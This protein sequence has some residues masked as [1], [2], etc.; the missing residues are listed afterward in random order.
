MK[1]FLPSFPKTKNYSVPFFFS[2][3]LLFLSLSLPSRKKILKNKFI[4]EKKNRIV[5]IRKFVQ[6]SKNSIFY[7]FV[8]NSMLLKFQCGDLFYKNHS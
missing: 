5:Q 2:Q 3:F 7:L 1:C 8:T 6:N 4:Y